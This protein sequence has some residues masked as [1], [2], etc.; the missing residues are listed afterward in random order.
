MNFS[1]NDLKHLKAHSI[2][3]SKA[4]RQLT[5]LR[6]GQVDVKL[7]RPCVL[8]DGIISL[9][10]STHDYL[11]KSFA[12]AVAT[13]SLI[14]FIPASGAASRMFSQLHADTATLEACRS[15]RPD[16]QASPAE[17]DLRRFFDELTS[18]AFYPEL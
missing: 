14:R 8:G 5:Q 4:V 11:N 18:F 16:S 2:E 9:Q 7:E 10:A 1:T 12:A 6:T 15:A 3:S 13:G 17:L